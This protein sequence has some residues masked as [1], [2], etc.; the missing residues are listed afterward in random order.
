MKRPISLLLLFVFAAMQIYFGH[1][2]LTHGVQGSAWTL[3]SRQA[4]GMVQR[5]GQYYLVTPTESFRLQ[6][7]PGGVAAQ[8]SGLN[9]IDVPEPS[10]A[11]V[12]KLALGPSALPLVGI[13]GPVYPSPD[14]ASVVWVDPATRLA[15]LSTTG[16]LGLNRLSRKLGPVSTAI[17]APNSSQLAVAGTGPQG[18]GAYVWSRSGGVKAVAVP[19]A[20]LAVTALGFTARHDLMAALNNGRVIEQQRG[21]LALPVLSPLYL[22]NGRAD[23]LGET[24]EHAIFRSEGRNQVWNRPDL[25]WVGR[26]AF[27]AGGQRAA[28]LS[29][30]VGGQWK[31]LV[32]TADGIHTV[33]ALPYGKPASYQLLGF[34]TSHWIMVVVPDGAHAGTYAWHLS[35]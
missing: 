3:V 18:P 1:G 14:G 7:S 26:A 30:T 6:V 2:A 5:Q 23:I 27:S 15:Y 31:L 33:I 19:G 10:G 11:G 8:R 17:W 35:G 34:L 4:G 13:G 12:W 22:D 9:W 21:L 28:I 20:P 25:K 32:Y 29:R 24:P 16:D